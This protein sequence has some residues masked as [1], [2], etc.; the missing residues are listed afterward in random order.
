LVTSSN[1]FSFCDALNGAG[2]PCR[3]YRHEASR[4]CI[5]HD[6]AYREQRLANSSAGGATPAKSSI[7]DDVLVDLGDAAGIQAVL[8]L[9]VRLE[10]LGRINPARSRNIIR[11]LSVAQRNLTA[12]RNARSVVD[13]DRYRMGREVTADVIDLAVKE[14]AAADAPAP[15]P[16]S[17]RPRSEPSLESLVR[18][19]ER[20]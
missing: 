5:F 14:A 13:A 8:D 4:F 18:L 3:A 17:P 7:L 15:A 10:L 19:F 9:T 12:S 1:D 2:E 20:R 11:A 6:P 16:R